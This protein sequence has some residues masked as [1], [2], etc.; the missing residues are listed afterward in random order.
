MRNWRSGV[1]FWWK[2]LRPT[3]PGL[4]GLDWDYKETKPQI[5]VTIDYDRAAELGVTIGT[6]GRTLETMLGS[7]RVTTFIEDGQQYDVILEAERDLQRTPN[8]LKALYVRSERSDALI[9]LANL[10]SL[11]E[12][13]DSSSLNRYNRGKGHHPAGKS[14]RWTHLGRRPGIHGK[15]GA[16]TSPRTGYYR[17]QRNIAGLRQLFTVGDVRLPAGSRRCLSGACR[18]I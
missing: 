3:T 11:E 15:S 6:I 12:F 7:R 2:K 14:R 16:R 9:P 1:I 18:P 17:L 13:A 5:K 10:V 4:Q 8:D